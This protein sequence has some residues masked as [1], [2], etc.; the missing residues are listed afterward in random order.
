[1]YNEMLIANLAAKFDGLLIKDT[2]KPRR[3]LRN[4]NIK[5]SKN[6]KYFIALVDILNN[7][8]NIDSDLFIEAQIYWAQ[9][10][11]RYCTPSWLATEMSIKRYIEFLKTRDNINIVY[12]DEYKKLVLESL[13]QSILFLAKKMKEYNLNTIDEV[14]NYKKENALI[15]ESFNWINTYSITKPF[16]AIYKKYIEYYSQMDNDIKRDIPDPK[17]LVKIRNYIMINKEL[18]TFCKSIIKDVI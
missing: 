9:K 14:F 12:K 18:N 2:G 17:D 6:Y 13:K 1:M 7:F 8:P 16:L 3:S 5:E 15:P 4:S 10:N 11:N